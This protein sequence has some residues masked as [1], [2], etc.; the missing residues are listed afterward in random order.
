MGLQRLPSSCPVLST[1]VGLRTLLGPGQ[2]RACSLDPR[3]SLT[4][5]QSASDPVSVDDLLYIR[6]NCATHQ[7]Y[8]DLFEPVLSQ[9]KLLASREW[10]REGREGQWDWILHRAAPGAELEVGGIRRGK[11][12]VEYGEGIILSTYC[13]PDPGYHMLSFIYS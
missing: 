1:G 4:L 12:W 7:I 6:D 13:V 5:W 2:H 3:Y 8:Y 11:S 10:S 9:F